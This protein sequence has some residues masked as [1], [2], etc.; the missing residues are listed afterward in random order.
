[1]TLYARILRDRWPR[2][3]VPVRGVH[4]TQSILRARGHFRIEHG[5]HPVARLLAGMLRL[6][7]A[8]AAIETRLTVT[9]RGLGEHWERRFDSARVETEQFE[10]QFEGEVDAQSGLVERFGLLEFRF[11]LD[12]TDGSLIYVQREAALAWRSARVRIPARLAP[13]IDAREDPAAADAVNVHVRV[14]LPVVGPLMTYGGI[15]EVE[16]TMKDR[17]ADTMKA[18]HT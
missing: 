4:T 15:I 3:A 6:P 14:T 10:G 8:G 17:L 1:M 16:D 7:P 18:R 11:Q 9:A 12:V 13:R 5:R 2:L